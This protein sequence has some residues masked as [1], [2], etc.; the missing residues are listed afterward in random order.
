M[1]VLDR[2]SI[3]CRRF[4]VAHEMHQQGFGTAAANQYPYLH[5]GQIK[6]WPRFLSALKS[7]AIE[8][9]GPKELHYWWKKL[10][11]QDQAWLA[12]VP[13]DATPFTQLAVAQ[14]LGRSF[15]IPTLFQAPGD[16]TSAD[17]R[18]TSSGY[19]TALNNRKI[20]ESLIPGSMLEDPRELNWYSPLKLVYSMIYSLISWF[21]AIACIG[22]F[23]SSF[24]DHNPLVRYVADSSY[25]IYLA[26]I[27]LLPALHILIS[28][29]P[30]PALIK[31]PLLNLV[32]FG[33]LFASYH[34]L[35]RST[36]MGKLLNGR[37][38]PWNSMD[39]SKH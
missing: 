3:E 10:R 36:W 39:C 5:E 20:L 14:K 13:E 30:V 22:F 28:Q 15:N 6:D 2:T 35:V 21:L 18:S 11:P 31:F 29:W 19:E 37:K 32:A 34:F 4:Y 7:G 23:Q 27:P 16:E 38:Y 25:W 26:H 17:H 9:K 1:E 8:D 24:T 12:S 33:L